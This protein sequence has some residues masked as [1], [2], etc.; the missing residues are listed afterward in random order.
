MLAEA[1]NAE[2]LKLSLIQIPNKFEYFFFVTS[3]VWKCWFLA[4]IVLYQIL[5][6]EALDAFNSTVIFHTLTVRIHRTSAN[7]YICSPS[8]NQSRTFELE[9]F[10]QYL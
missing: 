8:V 7:M 3:E 5:R 2:R 9:S 4:T 10:N 1:Y 6:K